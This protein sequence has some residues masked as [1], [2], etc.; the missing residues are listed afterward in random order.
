MLDK[1]Q[2]EIYQNL[3]ELF[4]S[5]AVDE[6]AGD[7]PAYKKK[8]KTIASIAEILGISTEIIAVSLNIKTGDSIIDVILPDET[9]DD[10][11]TDIIK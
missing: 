3:S 7:M 5:A 1:I 9:E 10:P 4:T 11:G 8:L 2:K 6:M